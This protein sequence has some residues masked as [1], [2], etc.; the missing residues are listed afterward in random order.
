[1]AMC[2]IISAY[3]KLSKCLGRH[4]WGSLRDHLFQSPHFEDGGTEPREG[5]ELPETAENL[6]PDF[7]T[8]QGGG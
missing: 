4:S 8:S 1:M 7:L 3:S 5:N 6:N 2:P